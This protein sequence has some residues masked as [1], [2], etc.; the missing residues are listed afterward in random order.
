MLKNLDVSHNGISGDGAQQLA[1]SVLASASLETFS[2][3]PLKELRA[4]SL[5]QLNLSSKGL[6]PAEGI[7]IAEVLKVTAVLTSLG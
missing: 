1:A 3:V 2:N 4:D 7:V 6:G 5:G